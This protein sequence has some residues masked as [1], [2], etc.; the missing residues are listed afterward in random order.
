MRRPHF[1]PF[2]ATFLLLALLP[3]QEPKPP[4][5][6]VLVTGASSGIGKKTTE[7][8]AQSGFF[9]YATARKP[10]DLEA[11]GKLAN[12]QAIPLDV[13]KQE[14]IDAAVATVRAGGHPLHGVVC[15]AG[16]AVMAPLLELHERDLQQQFDVNVFGAWRTAKAFAP[17]LLEHKGRIAF[18]GSLSGTVNWAFGGPYCM[19]KHAVE[20]LTDVLALELQQFGV[21]VSVV[22][23]GNYRSEI[24][25][26]MQERLVAGGYGG[27]GSR[28]QKQLERLK[29]QPTDR[30]QYPEPDDVAKA[31]L[32]AMRDDQPK[33][34][35]L[36]VPN[37]REAELT[38]RAAVQRVVQL[39]QAQ[40]F[41]Y[42]RDALVK[43]LD[44]ALRAK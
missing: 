1:V 21:Q 22:E 25:Q 15:N 17:L 30:A 37:Q 33:R 14:Q 3:A 12:V 32:A 27:D 31:F 5:P 19:S 29:A 10:Q 36:V 13:T 38:I 9:V 11:L 24:M 39:N 26:G 41:A 43:L 42:D 40:P 4:Q 16:I 35:Y 20:A 34:R 23:P 18:T 7:V 2:A 8:L 44:E 6:A 28:W